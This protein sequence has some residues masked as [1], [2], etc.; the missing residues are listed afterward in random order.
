MDVDVSK[1]C[2]RQKQLEVGQFIPED[3]ICFRFGEGM[4]Q[5][6]SSVSK[7]EKYAQL[8]TFANGNNV[9]ELINQY[10]NYKIPGETTTDSYSDGVPMERDDG[11]TKPDGFT[12]YPDAVPI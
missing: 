4:C 11:L 6:L 5:P 1:P 3:F 9:P 10:H 2:C 12:L 7:L 8:V